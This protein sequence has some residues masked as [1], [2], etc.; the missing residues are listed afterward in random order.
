MSQTERHKRLRLLLKHHNRQRKQQAKKIDILC[1]DLIAAQRHFVHRLS[2][3]DF[4]AQFYKALLGT[5]DLR[6]LLG[7]AGRFIQLDVPRASV[8][9]CLRQGDGCELHVIEG[10]GL[11]GQHIEEC[12]SDELVAS[13]CKANR[14]CAL[15]D[16][17]AMGLTDDG[18][19]LRG[20]SAATLP[21]NDLGR[22]LGFV[23]LSR[24]AADPLTTDE[25]ERVGL[26]TCGL[27][28]AIRGCAV[29]LHARE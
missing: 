18:P 24:A 12:F 1:N 26:I 13:V 5:S 6:T 20:V 19:V 2:H 23:L 4:A 22:S 17:V 7:R 9:F 10:Q 11:H 15:D 16:L 27:S 14:P 8:A 29:A 28:R 25:V 3:V 21:L